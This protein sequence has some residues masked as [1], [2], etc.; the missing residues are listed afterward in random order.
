MIKTIIILSTVIL[1]L[2]SISASKAEKS[3]WDFLPNGELLG[4][5]GGVHIH[6]TLES[7]INFETLSCNIEVWTCEPWP[8]GLNGGPI[9]IPCNKCYSM[10]GFTNREIITLTGPLDIKGKLDFPDGTKVQL[11]TTGIFVQGELSMKSTK[12]VDGTPDVVISLTGSSDVIFTPD[13]Q[14]AAACDE[15]GCNFGPKPIV[16]AG[17]RLN[18]DGMPDSCSTWT[19]VADYERIEKPTPTKYRKQPTI[20]DT[21]AGT[22]DFTLLEE[23]FENGIGQWNGNLGAKEQ[24]LSGSHD[25][26][27][28]LRVSSR[29]ES[30]QGPLYDLNRYLRECAIPDTDYLFRAKIRLSSSDGSS[31]SDCSTSG[32][33]CPGLNFGFLNATDDLKWRKLLAF[34]GTN[35]V[36]GQWQDVKASFR[37]FPDYVATDNIFTTFLFYGPEAGIDISIDDITIALPPAEAYPDPA[38]VCGNLVQNGNAELLDGFP[39]PMY[40]FI[41]SSTILVLDDDSGGQYFFMTNRKAGHDSLALDITPQCLVDGSVYTFSMKIKVD[42]AVEVMPVVVIKTHTA[43]EDRIF[44]VVAY[45][46]VSSTAIGWTTC[47]NDFTFK[48]HHSVSPKV[49][50]VIYLRN[51]S[52]SDV[53]Y[54]DISFT[55]KSGG[56][57]KMVLLESVSCWDSNASVIFPSQTLLYDDTTITSVESVTGNKITTSDDVLPLPIAATESSDTAS[58]IGLLSRNIL[59]ENGDNSSSGPYL[60][61]LKTPGVPQKIQGIEFNGFGTQGAVGKHPINFKLSGDS[62]GSIIAKNSIRNSKNRCINIHGTNNVLIDGNVAHR[63]YGHCFSLEGEGETGNVFQNNFGSETLKPNSLI[64]DSSDSNPATFYI[65]YPTNSWIGNCAAGSEAYGFWFEF[66][67]QGEAWISSWLAPLTAFEDNKSHSNKLMGMRTSPFGYNPSVTATLVNSTIYRNRGQGIF[68]HN[69]GNLMIKGGYLADNKIGI[70]ILQDNTIGIE[71]VKIIGY[72]PEYKSLAMRHR[73]TT[74]TFCVPGANGGFIGVRLH[75]TEKEAKAGLAALSNVLFSDFDPECDSNV[76]AISINPDT[77]RGSTFNTKVSITQLS[78]DGFTSVANK[79]NFCDAKEEGVDDVLLSD[80]DGSLNPTDSEPGYIVSDNHDMV[81]VS[82]T[83]IAGSCGYFCPNVAAAESD[84]AFFAD[85]YEYKSS[86]IEEDYFCLHNTNFESGATYWRVQNS[87][88]GLAIVT[89]FDSSG[90][91][92]KVSDR[93]KSGTGG[94]W[95]DFSPDCLAVNSWYEITADVKMTEKGTETIFDCN[96]AYLWHTDPKSCAGISLFSATSIPPLK[97]VGFTVGPYDA[98]GWAKLYGVFKATEDIVSQPHLSFVVGRAAIASDITVDNVVLKP[99]TN[100]SVGVTDCSHPL[101]NG[102]A[103]LG[104]HRMWWIYGQDDVGS[105]IELSQGYGGSMHA[106][107][108]AGIRDKKNRGMVQMMDGT[109]FDPGSTWIIKAKFKFFEE[110]GTPVSCDK[111]KRNGSDTCPTFQMMPDGKYESPPMYNIDEAE[112]IEGEWNDYFSEYTVLKNST[113]MHI[114]VSSVNPGFNYELDNIELIRF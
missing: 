109:C 103:E 95:Q 85:G 12:L 65:S 50:V 44:D 111:T 9:E 28:Y 67:K 30:F 61:V 68:T 62:A 88:G 10:G 49:E 60:V 21:S 108:H 75:I 27:N 90:K 113:K 71:D 48:G 64:P 82:C 35:F 92:L 74:P 13:S 40:P 93:T 37:F 89:G 81:A 79:V 105:R 80:I 114:L 107:K 32:T 17:G 33:N 77:T 100:L 47:T 39:A 96:P 8:F 43:E 11:E 63:T 87:K 94:I 86:D 97:E 41:K 19:T 42:S 99:A 72:S 110:D 16:V 78:F 98:S 56:V 29:T 112:M 15:N 14:N 46:P 91:A 34:D 66:K 20:P 3:W 52:N 73:S 25:G 54:D 69:T 5:G 1:T 70:D 83:Q 76:Y 104:D 59:F 23:R 18:I 31:F 102:D 106:F 84:L 38:N 7:S 55:F 2:E 24:I 58:E 53:S 57:S 36:D 6:R 51:D 101:Q 45:C 4:D 26:S 22:C